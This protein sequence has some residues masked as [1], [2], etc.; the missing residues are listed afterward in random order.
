MKVSVITPT[1]HREK[2]VLES[3]QSV[4][5]IQD[6]SLEH[7]ICDDS[8]DH[9]AA[10]AVQSIK[11]NRLIYT[12]MPTPTGG[13]PARVRNHMAN[14][15]R[16]EYLYF[17]DDDDRVDSSALKQV[18]SQMEARKA[19]VAIAN[20]V[21]F[22]E[23]PEILA[24]ERIFFQNA[25][26]ILARNISPRK[27]VAQLLFKTPILVCIACVIRRDAFFAMGGFD[28]TLTPFEDTE[29][30]LR[31]VRKYGYI[32]VS[33]PLLQRRCGDNCLSSEVSSHRIRECYRKMRSKYK[34]DYGFWDHSL[35]R[36]ISK[37]S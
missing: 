25:T 33:A 29:L 10:D 13:H 24:H 18:I 26:N 22:G 20:V 2:E 31:A 36:L 4:L 21:P 28:D 34:N 15:A 30:Y 35:M 8:P 9:S 5:S 3:I 14:Q 16:G 17:L 32:H 12:T 1:F 19:S 6:L 23:K 7:L 11:D 37:F 27:V